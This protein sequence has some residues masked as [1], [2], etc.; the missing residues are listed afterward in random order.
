MNVLSKAVIL[1]TMVSILSA[2]ALTTAPKHSTYWIKQGSDYQTHRD[3]IKAK[4]HVL[5]CKVVISDRV[6]AKKLTDKQNQDLID[7]CMEAKHYQ[8]VK[9]WYDIEETAKK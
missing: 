4:D 2:C 7:E 3:R 8:K 5:A 6:D 9:N 1:S